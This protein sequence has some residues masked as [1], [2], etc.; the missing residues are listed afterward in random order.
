MDIKK[1]KDETQGMTGKEIKDYIQQMDI[2]DKEELLNNRQFIED[3][4]SLA[5]YYIVDIIKTLDKDELKIHFIN[6][7]EIYGINVLEVLRTCTDEFKEQLVL[8]GDKGYDYNKIISLLPREKIREFI[9]KNHNLLSERDVS[10][11]III[12][13]IEP[14]E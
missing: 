3:E 13:S 9:Q 1:I 8:N 2:H 11:Q 7:Y 12:D 14:K 6:Q 5:D 4:L 10:I